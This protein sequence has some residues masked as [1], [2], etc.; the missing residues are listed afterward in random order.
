MVY[1]SSWTVTSA[2]NSVTVLALNAPTISGISGNSLNYSGGIGSQFV[3]L[4]T[5]VITA[6]LTNWTRLATNTAPSGSFTI[7]V[8][9]GASAFYSIKSE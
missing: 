7:P 9:S 6:P 5:N 4:G 8:G 1:N 3:L 2:T